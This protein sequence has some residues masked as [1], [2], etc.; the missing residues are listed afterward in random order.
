MIPPVI[1]KECLSVVAS[2]R[3][4]FMLLD[5]FSPE[6][7]IL[8]VNPHSRG[9]MKLFDGDESSPGRTQSQLS[10]S[11][12]ATDKICR[13]RKSLESP[14]GVRM[15]TLPGALPGDQSSTS[16]RLLPALVQREPPR[17]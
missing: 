10:H 13:R 12:D 14:K 7:H 15:E 9:G 16:R 1:S 2:D 11:M 4:S 8:A 6:V 17:H 5:T 3:A